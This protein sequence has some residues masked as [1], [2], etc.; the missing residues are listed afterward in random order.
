MLL[1]FPVVS[2]CAILSPNAVGWSRHP[3][4]LREHY[5]LDGWAIVTQHVAIHQSLREDQMDLR[6]CLAEAIGWK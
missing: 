4:N 2:T 5:A 3:G 1:R 6:K